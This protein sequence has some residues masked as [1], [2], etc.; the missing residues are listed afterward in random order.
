MPRLTPA[1]LYQVNRQA[2]FSPAQAVMMTAIQLG[3]SGGRSDAVGDVALETS[4]WG[5]SVGIS[6]I[7]TLKAQTGTGGVRDVLKLTDPLA[8]AM[9]AYSLSGRGTDWS[10]WSVYN[11]GAYARDDGSGQTPLQKAQ[12]AAAAAGDTAGGGGAA[13]VPTAGGP[14]GWAWDKLT[15]GTFSAIRDLTIQSLFAG[16]GIGLVLLGAGHLMS[17]VRESITAKYDGARVAVRKAVVGA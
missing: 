1:Q 10:P 4:T 17:P 12:A 11:S 3:E 9:A 6:Q 15:A 14:L 7:R 8:N 2:G 16:A 13:I 5:P